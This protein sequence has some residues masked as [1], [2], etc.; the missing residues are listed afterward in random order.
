MSAGVVN[1]AIQPVDIRYIVFPG[2][3]AQSIS[4]TVINALA[5]VLGAAGIYLSFL[6][7]RQTT[8]PRMVNFYLILGLLLIATGMYVGIYVYHS[9]V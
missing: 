9:K 4:E 5:L 3:T 6:S 8:K 7:G 1:A 2:R